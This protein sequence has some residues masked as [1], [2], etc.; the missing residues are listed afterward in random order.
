MIDKI[1]Y[2][3][4]FV[5]LTREER[6]ALLERFSPVYEVEYLH[7][8]TLQFRP[9]DVK[10]TP[11]GKEVLMKVIGEVE[12]GGVQVFAV[13]PESLNLVCDNNVPHITVATQKGVPPFRSNTV[14]KE[15]GDFERVE[16]Y[17]PGRVGAY[18]E[19]G[20]IIYEE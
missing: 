6:K 3:G 17:I 8:L 14:L 19:D 12:G 9:S 18:L 15:Y 7:H 11:F 2:T 20:S 16:F 10:D 5:D 4:V 1:I 13:D